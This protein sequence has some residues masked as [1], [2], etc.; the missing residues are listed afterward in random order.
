[1]RRQQQA[2]SHSNKRRMVCAAILAALLLLSGVPDA[3]Q[4]SRALAANAKVP[5][6]PAAAAPA[7]TAKAPDQTPA[8]YTYQ[9]KGRRDPF[10]PLIVKEQHKKR[11]NLPPLER[12]DISEFKLSGIVWGGFGYNAILEGPDGKGYFIRQ[13]TIIGPNRGVVKSITKT[14]V[15]V[16]EKY[17]TY[18]GQMQRKEIVM[19]LRKKQEGME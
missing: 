3:D 11:A 13:G 15:V 7:E 5:Q 1:M 4:R 8:P 12:Y 18:T 9:P 10:M 2:K 16:E 6:Q 17:K 14:G 19:P